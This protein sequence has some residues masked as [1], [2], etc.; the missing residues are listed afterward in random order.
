M[1]NDL[2]HFIPELWSK[3]IQVWKRRNLVATQITNSEERAGLSYGDRIHRPISSDLVVNDYTRGTAVALQD[4]NSTDE[5]MDINRAKE[6]SFYV[7]ALDKKQTKYDPERIYT[8]KAGYELSNEIDQTVLAEVS[9]ATYTFDDG[10]IGGIAGNPITLAAATTQGIVADLEAE[11]SSADIE[12]TSPWCL[13]VTPKVIA[14]FSKAFVASGFDKAD[15][16]LTNGFQGMFQGFMVYKSNNILHTNLLTTTA[17]L[18]NGDTVTVNG[19]VFTLKTSGTAAAAGDVS[20]GASAAATV[21]NL[22]DA[23]NGTG[24]PGASTYI[25]VSTANRNLLKAKKVTAALSGTANVLFKTAG[26]VVYAEASSNASFG[27]QRAKC[28]ACKKGAVDLVMQMEPEV[29]F[30]KVPDKSG[31]NTL[32]IDLYGVKTFQEGKDRMFSFDVV[33]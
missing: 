17:N 16:T 7:D 3:R 14:N 31:Y 1:A 30:N 13:V 11:M 27:T 28:I 32:V 6:V 25:A 2:Q 22:I 15:T 12:S 26:K 9:N 23:V 5:Y 24:T 8:E 18:T 33:A 19:V 4:V 29:Q 21:A 10:S 20:L